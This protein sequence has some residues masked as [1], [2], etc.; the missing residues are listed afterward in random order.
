MHIK[1][2]RDKIQTGKYKITLHARKRMGQRKISADDMKIAIAA[3][4]IIED[5]PDDKPFPSCLIMGNLVDKG[6]LYVVCALSDI[7]HIITVHWLDPAKWLDPITRRER[8][9]D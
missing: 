5:Y 2:I 1:E 6:P 4:K 9:Y 8:K 3:G 7:A